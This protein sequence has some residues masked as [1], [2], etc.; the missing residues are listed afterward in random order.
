MKINGKFI[1][2]ALIF[3]AL[4]ISIIYNFNGF[5]KAKWAD[6]GP[7]LIYGVI[8]IYLSLLLFYLYKSSGIKRILY[9]TIGFFI[10]AADRIVQII[11]QEQQVS[12]N[13]AYSLVWPWAVSDFIMAVGFILMAYGLWR[14]SK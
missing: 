14:L 7:D 12:I 11:L 3:L 6:D 13:Y 1:I 5:E 9:I 4:A 10:V 2:L 8:V